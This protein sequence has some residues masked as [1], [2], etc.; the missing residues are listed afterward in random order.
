MIIVVVADHDFFNLPI[1][2]HLT[3]EVLVESIEV[4]LQLGRIHLVLLIICRIL[5]EIWKENSLAVGWFDMLSRTSVAVSARAD[6]VVKRAVDLL[7][8]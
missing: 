4:V 7:S 5:V 6:F 8:C 2:A 1:F 3:P